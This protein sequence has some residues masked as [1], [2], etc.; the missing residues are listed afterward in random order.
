GRSSGRADR[1]CL[2]RQPQGRQLHRAHGA[3]RGAPSGGSSHSL[4]I[5]RQRNRETFMYRILAI[6]VGQGADPSASAVV[7]DVIAT[8]HGKEMRPYVAGLSNGL[9][10]LGL[11]PGTDFDID[12]LTDAPRALKKRVK[13]SIDDRRPDA[14]FA[15]STT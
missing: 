4:A 9:D 13:D 1:S 14:I 6:A 12:Y 11:R 15:M 8:K 2:L 10:K 7:R 5:S 3:A